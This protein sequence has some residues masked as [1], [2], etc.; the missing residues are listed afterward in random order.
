MHE[1]GIVESAI[2]AA[3]KEMEQRKAHRLLS[4]KLRI[5]AL[6]GVDPQALEFAFEA[7]TRSCSMEGVQL[8]VET[9]PALAS[10]TNCN[11]E[12]TT[13]DRLFLQCPECGEFGGRLLRGREIEL[14]RLEME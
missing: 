7:V 9:V 3:R 13:G 10:C 11:H 6:A 1:V 4:L 8:E 2:R 12:F 5:G 14:A